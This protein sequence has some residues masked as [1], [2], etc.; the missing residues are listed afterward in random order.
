VAHLDK[1][2]AERLGFGEYTV[3]R[4]LVD[5]HAGHYGVV[6]LDLGL[7]SGER[8]A[9]RLAQAAAKT[10]LV[11]LRRKIAVSTCHAVTTR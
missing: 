6:T 1:F 8:G 11:S 10:D 5:Q 3:E 9:D 2:E 7:E 4:S